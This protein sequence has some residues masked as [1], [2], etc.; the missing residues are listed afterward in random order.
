MN[1]IGHLVANICVCKYICI[2]R[3]KCVDSAGI[4]SFVF[5]LAVTFCRYIYAWYHGL[6]EGPVPLASAV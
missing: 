3:P 5:A 1:R 2:S 6:L 4:S